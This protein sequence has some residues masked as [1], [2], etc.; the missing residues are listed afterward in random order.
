MPMIWVIS[1]NPAFGET[2]VFH[3]GSL[4]SVRSGPPESGRWKEVDPPDLMV[5]LATDAPSGD[6]AGL[7]RLIGFLHGIRPWRRAPP[8][9][10]Y[11]EPPGGHPAGPLARRLIDDRPLALSSWPPDPEQILSD[12][13]GLLAQ[14]ALPM[15]LRERARRAWVTA[16]MERLYAPL[17]L[18]T[19]RQAIDPRNAAWPVLLIGERGTRRGLIARYI[20]NLAEPP[21]ERLIAIPTRDLPGGRSEAHLLEASAGERVSIYLEG[22]EQAGRALQDELA[23]ALGASGALGIEPIRWIASTARPE[24]LVPALRELA[25]L[26][27]RLPPL[28]ARS[29]FRELAQSVLEAQAE[30]R[31]RR[32]RIAEDTLEVLQGYAWPGNLRELEGVL[33][34][35]LAACPGEELQAAQLCMLPHREPAAAGEPLPPAPPRD[36]PDLPETSHEEEPTAPAEPAPS[37]AEESSAAAAELAARDL[38]RQVSGPLA[39]EIRRPLLAIR[40]CAGLLEQRP[41]DEGLRRELSSLLET[42]AARIEQA[43]RRLDQFASL[44]PG[45]T[46]RRSLVLLEELDRDAPPASTDEARLRFAVGG[47]LDRALRMTP[48]GGDIYLGTHYLPERGEEPARHRLLIRFHSPEDVIVPPSGV[49]GPPMPLEVVLARTVIAALGGR[50]AVD[51]SGTAENVI[52]IDL[53]A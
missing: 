1:E 48:T 31:G 26:R 51:A 42:D 45:E 21:R 36:A 40:T 29:D 4:G 32:V 9:V 10:L 15:S 33:D 18:P 16:Q 28:R 47:L 27:V 20:H 13:A 46:R 22:I 5:L 11:I 50:F 23:Q 52:L 43:L 17:D 49:P 39:E 25:W 38:V 30:R 14:P 7:D 3:L 44:G 35:S 34:A 6:L 19:L 37:P 12:A 53:P 24:R 2:L 8:P 41:D